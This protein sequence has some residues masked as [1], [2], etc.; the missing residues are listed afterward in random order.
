MITGSHLTFCLDQFFFLTGGVRVKVLQHHQKL[1]EDKAAK[2]RNAAPWSASEEKIK[3]E[4]EPVGESGSLFIRNLWY[5]VTE[6]HI[7]ELFSKYGE[8]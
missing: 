6:E 2:S 8:V 3:K 7:R 5:S 1:P 4:A